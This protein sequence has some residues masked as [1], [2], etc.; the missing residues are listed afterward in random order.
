MSTKITYTQS[1]ET[2]SYYKP[3]SMLGNINGATV[4]KLKAHLGD[5]DIYITKNSFTI[6]SL[7][8]NLSFNATT[9]RVR[10]KVRYAVWENGYNANATKGSKDYLHFDA[11]QDYDVSE[12]VREGKRSWVEN[13]GRVKKESTPAAQFNGTYNEFYLT[14]YFKGERKSWLTPDKK[15][16][17]KANRLQAW[18]PI[19][20]IRMKIDGSGSEL[21]KSG[22]IGVSG[23]IR[24]TIKRI[25]NIKI[26]TTIDD[27]SSN[28]LLNP[29]RGN[30][31]KTDEKDMPRILDSLMCRGYDICGGYADLDSCKDRVLDYKKLNDYNRL[32]RVVSNK[33]TTEIFS[34]EGIEEYTSSIEK[35]LNVKVSAHAFGASFSNETS[36]T[37]KEDTSSKTGYKY[38]T[39]KDVFEKETYTVSGM[40]NP[41]SLTGFLTPEF[42]KDLN[43][44]NASQLVYK[45]GTHVLLGVK[46]GSNFFY[47]MKYKES[48]SKR[49]TSS[50][51]KNTTSISYNNDGSVK[52]DSGNKA[53][54]ETEKI[55]DD[56]VSNGG[57]SADKLTAYAK[58]LEAAKKT[59][60]EQAAKNDSK[61]SSGGGGK[62]IGGSIEVSYSE[63]TASTSL[64]EDKST[65][66][67]CYGNGG[68]AAL[69][70]LI[71]RNNDISKMEEWIKTVYKNEPCFAD[72]VRD[73]LVP[74]YEF[75]PVG[76]RINA[77]DVKKASE[78]YQISKNKRQGVPIQK[79]IRVN[80]N[81]LGNKSNTQL[82][83][84]DWE[85]SSH[86][87]KKIY[88]RVRVELVNFDDGHCGYAISFTVKEGGRTGAQSILMSHAEYSIPMA[89]GCSTMAIDTSKLNGQCVFE[90]DAE[91]VGKFHGWHDATNSVR[92]SGS[93]RKVI[94]CDGALVGVQLDGSGDDWD[95]IGIRGTLV[96]PWIGY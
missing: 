27:V 39:Q 95:H 40:T 58:Y 5:G 74:L 30:E 44:L 85:V 88:W 61:G 37:F 43:M 64:Q 87:G 75:I 93:A 12:F 83:H 45:Y 96:I 11:Y 68:D 10:L 77:Q 46:L 6:T 86:T 82:I 24:F 52:K 3:F 55:Y 18:M 71:S 50:T 76:Y 47:S 54:S 65:E 19:S 60:P 59:T 67:K 32:K 7:Q 1:V 73:S 42:L 2:K 15:W 34:G 70:S 16:G 63:S 94:D 66:I 84:G 36:T 33:N 22:N 35:S 72:F 8:A 13:N 26:T 23:Y 79:S 28:T 4:K 57:L 41:G 49:S 38:L 81:T 80:F 89:V 48:S 90:S 21:T 29:T 78:D 25:D 91:W 17:E 53:K 62:G 9:N 92:S 56:L 51:F 31:I 69:L 20:D 14:D